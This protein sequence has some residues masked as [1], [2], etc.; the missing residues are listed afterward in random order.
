MVLTALCK[1]NAIPYPPVILNGAPQ[2]I[3][4]Q[5]D[6][7]RAVKDPHNIS[8]SL[9]DTRCSTQ[10]CT[11]QVLTDYQIICTKFNIKR[12]RSN[13]LD[14]RFRP[15]RYR[16]PSLRARL[17]IRNSAFS[18]RCVQDDMVGIGF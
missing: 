2:E 11:N 14:Q 15:K 17:Y 5:E 6:D 10:V 7:R 1:V 3:Q 12:L 13:T 4:D 9:T 18:P 8:I 16:G